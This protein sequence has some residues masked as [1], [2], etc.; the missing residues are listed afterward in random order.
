MMEEKGNFACLIILNLDGN[1]LEPNGQAQSKQTDTLAR[2]C[3]K[4]IQTTKWDK[5]E[6]KST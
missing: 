2:F 6:I 1:N 4:K 3:S 5:K